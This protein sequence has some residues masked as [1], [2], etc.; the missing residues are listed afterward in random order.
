MN[1]QFV[2]FLVQTSVLGLTVQHVVIA[3]TGILT[4]CIPDIPSSVRD[5]LARERHLEREALV[6]QESTPDGV[7]GRRVKS[8]LVNGERSLRRTVSHQPRV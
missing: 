8:A 5:K 2:A 1:I 4:Y 7:S 6:A 3:L